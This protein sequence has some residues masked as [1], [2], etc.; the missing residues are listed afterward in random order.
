MTE[1]LWVT[2]SRND[3]LMEHIRREGF[4]VS[5]MDMKPAIYGH[6]KHMLFIRTRARKVG[7]L[8]KIVYDFDDSALMV[9][10][11]TSMAQNGFFNI[12]T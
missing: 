9:I 12:A 2:K 8:K 3:A 7:K 6:E 11:E 5:V 1:A 4:T 10:H